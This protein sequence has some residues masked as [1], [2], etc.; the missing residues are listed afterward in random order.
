ME[1]DSDPDHRLAHLRFVT[2]ADGFYSG[3]LI[4]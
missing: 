4:T 1:K 2:A 3:T